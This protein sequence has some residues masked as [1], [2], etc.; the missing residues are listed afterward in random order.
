MQ[1]VYSATPADWENC[2]RC[3]NEYISEVLRGN[4][5]YEHNSIGQL[6]GIYIHQFCVDTGCRLEGLSETLND[7]DGWRVYVKGLRAISKT[8]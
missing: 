2:R 4:R 3:K 6:A 8:W 1:S 7:R 5:T